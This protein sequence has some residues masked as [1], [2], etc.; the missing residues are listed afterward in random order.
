[1]NFFPCRVSFYPSFLPAPAFLTKFSDL[2]YY[3][4]HKA[5]SFTDLREDRQV[6]SCWT[7]ILIFTFQ[8]NKYL[9]LSI[10][11]NE[12]AQTGINGCLICTFTESK[13]L[14]GSTISSEVYTQFSGDK[15][16]LAKPRNQLLLMQTKPTNS[17]PATVQKAK[18]EQQSAVNLLSILPTEI[19][20][21][22]RAGPKYS[23][24]VQWNI[25]ELKLYTQSFC[26]DWGRQGKID[27]LKQ[28]HKHHCTKVAFLQAH[29]YH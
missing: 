22:T 28:G 21:S 8:I 10:E 5:S 4:Q 14:A 17:A 12:V 27:W 29:L 1:M 11:W 26:K 9:A 13:G 2:P 7:Q 6:F 15:G 24:T 23:W 3:P 16:H 20:I 19:S 18:W 25:H